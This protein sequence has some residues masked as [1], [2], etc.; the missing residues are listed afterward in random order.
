MRE[1][2]DVQEMKT[3]KAMQDKKR[4][5][6]ERHNRCYHRILSDAIYCKD[7]TVKF[8]RFI[9]NKIHKFNSSSSAI[10][11]HPSKENVY[12]TNTRIVNYRLNEIGDSSISSDVITINKVS[13]LDNDFN[14]LSYHY[15]YPTKCKNFSGIEDIRL[16]EFNQEVYYIGCSYQPTE[17]K[18]SIV[19]NKYIIGEDYNPIIIRPS[20]KTDN[21]WE[22]NWVF[23]KY[24][25]D[26]HVIYQW[27][28]MYICKI[29]YEAQKLNIVRETRMPSIFTS[30]R[31]STN[32]VEYEDKIWFIVHQTLIVHAQKFYLHHFVVF[33]KEMNLIGF[34]KPFK[35]E[36]KLVEYCIGMVVHKD[37]FILTYSTLDSTTKMM[38]ILPSVVKHLL[39]S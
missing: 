1:I 37:K 38:V 36:G 33:D 15:V 2:K 21:Q 18:V 34:S 29:D 9:L 7:N 19:S 6:L 39:H 17:D 31:G 3:D 13:I 11:R 5:S 22:K 26:L 28:P 35:F 32:G 20:F 30:F 16:F 14:E 12:V 4:I 23:L 10:I 27:N 25:G 24:Q 8:D